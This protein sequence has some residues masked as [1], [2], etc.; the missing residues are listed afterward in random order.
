[1]RRRSNVDEALYVTTFPFGDDSSNESGSE[2]PRNETGVYTTD[3]EKDVSVAIDNSMGPRMFQRE[4][5]EDSMP[6]MVEPSARD[7]SA[8]KADR[9]NH[10]FAQQKSAYRTSDHRSAF[11]VYKAASKSEER[12]SN[13]EKTNDVRVRHATSSSQ[14]SAKVNELYEQGRNTKCQRDFVRRG[15]N[16]KYQEKQCSR[17]LEAINS[18]Q[19]SYHRSR[20]VCTVPSSQMGIYRTDS[21][22]RSFRNS[23]FSDV[24]TSSCSSSYQ[25][26]QNAAFRKSALSSDERACLRMIR[27]FAYVYRNPSTHGFRTVENVINLFPTSSID[28]WVRLIQSHLQEVEIVTLDNMH[29]IIWRGSDNLA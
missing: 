9:S 22:P 16:E 21:S 11:G 26:D 23:S 27:D 19:P 28:Y 25:P 29:V 8:P 7:P 20:G 4:C 18:A 12:E 17:E 15:S 2:A 1:M 14:L 10:T 13:W 24:R 5:D 3:E 6:V